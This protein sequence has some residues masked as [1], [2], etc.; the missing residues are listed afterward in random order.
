MR[1][2]SFPGF[3]PA[4]SPH[5]GVQMRSPARGSA[6]AHGQGAVSQAGQYVPSPVR[7]S[8]VRGR[9]ASATAPKM[10]PKVL[11]AESMGD[12]GAAPVY[13]QAEVRRLEEQLDEAKRAREAKEEQT[14][15]HTRIGAKIGA[16]RDFPA[17][18]YVV[19]KLLGKGVYGKVFECA[20]SKY[21]CLVAV[22]V[23]RNL[24]EYR[25][26][27]MN[28]I[29]VLKTLQ[30][31]CGVLRLCRDFTHLNHVCI[32]VDLYGESLKQKLERVG[33]LTP[34][35]V[36]DVGLQLLHGI[37][38]MHK[39]GI[40]HTDLKTDN[41]L[42]YHRADEKTAAEN[43]DPTFPLAVRIVDLGSAAFESNWHP[44]MIGTSE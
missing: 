19:K 10:L 31:D 8:P 20:D 40:V 39:N 34:E 4:A 38:H 32:S 43:D 36:A 28:E 12:A 30:G 1:R 2:Q 22:K 44:P 6:A 37:Q 24:P 41:V 9:P 27:G 33:A 25:Q 35:Q 15:L 21:D 18:R 26:A 42:V 3:V 14:H 11:S 29:K 5:P 16:D 7:G 13:A 17:G 23:V